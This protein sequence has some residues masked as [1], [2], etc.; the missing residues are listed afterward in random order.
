M[1]KESFDELLSLSNSSK[2]KQGVNFDIAA[3]KCLEITDN[4]SEHKKLI[5]QIGSRISLIINSNDKSMVQDELSLAFSSVDQDLDQ[6]LRG[7]SNLFSLIL[8]ED[9]VSLDLENLLKDIKIDKQ[10]KEQFLFLCR[11]LD[12][13]CDIVD[14][15]DISY[16]NT[17][18]GIFLLNFN[19]ILQLVF[20]KN[21]ISRELL[22][23]WFADRCLQ[24]DGGLLKIFHE[25]LLQNQIDISLQEDHDYS[26]D[27]ALVYI[28]FAVARGGEISE[29]DTYLIKNQLKKNNVLSIDPLIESGFLVVENKKILTLQR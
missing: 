18:V 21:M 5:K 28:C 7:F 1:L 19:Q 24:I 26:I 2:D 22:F 16:P 4:L 25:A 20:G 15:F 17:A 3:V 13:Y 8:E 27:Y 11:S 12:A 29:R 10:I 14:A 6:S 23:D 9:R